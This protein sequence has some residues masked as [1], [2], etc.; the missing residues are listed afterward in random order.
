MQHDIKTYFLTPKVP[1]GQ[2]PPQDILG[3]SSL[4]DLLTQTD[5]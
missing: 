2:F 1:E 3:G 4:F 5:K